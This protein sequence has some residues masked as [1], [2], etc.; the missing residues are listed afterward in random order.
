MAR[1]LFVCF[2]WLAVTIRREL[3]Q[4]FFRDEC[5]ITEN[6]CTQQ[7]PRRAADRFMKLGH[8]RCRSRPAPAALRELRRCAE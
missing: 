4:R 6:R 8:H 1:I 7:P 3:D 2:A 5:W